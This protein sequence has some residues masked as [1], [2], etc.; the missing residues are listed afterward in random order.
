MG[1]RDEDRPDARLDQAGQLGGD[2]LDGPARLDVG[3]EQ[4]ARDEEEVHL[5]DER[6]IDRTGERRELSFALGGSLLAEIVVARAQVDV[7]GMDDP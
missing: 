5:L 2:P 1:A 6:E 7:G 3:V 4:V